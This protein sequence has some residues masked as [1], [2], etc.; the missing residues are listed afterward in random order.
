LATAAAVTG[1]IL[2]L[3]AA[4]MGNGGKTSQYA[5]TQTLQ[6]VNISVPIPTAIKG[7][8]IICDISSSTLKFGLKNA[9]PIVDVSITLL[10]S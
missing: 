10:L 7:K 3:F 6:D 8:D 1:C 5:W 2:V 4:A 9:T